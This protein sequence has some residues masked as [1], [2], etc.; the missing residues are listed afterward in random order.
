M[1]ARS[2]I[3]AQER[4]KKIRQPSRARRTM[5]MK[6]EVK[7][8][9]HTRR[10]QR[11]VASRLGHVIVLRWQVVGGHDHAEK[12]DGALGLHRDVVLE[13]VAVDGH[14]GGALAP[15]IVTLRARHTPAPDTQRDKR[16]HTRDN[17]PAQQG[18]SQE[19][20]SGPPPAS[21]SGPPHQHQHAIKAA[22]EER[23]PNLDARGSNGIAA[24]A[25][26]APAPPM[27][28]PHRRTL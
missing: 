19:S 21:P 8:D 13:D 28:P 27:A 9:I 1:Q 10:T 16:K 5:K 26:P 2:E 22:P 6:V 24:A 7:A 18:N 12:A 3:P 20:R 17:R 14:Q 25:P 11:S 15:L 4:A 23:A